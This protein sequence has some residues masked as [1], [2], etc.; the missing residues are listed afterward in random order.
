MKDVYYYVSTL[1]FYALI[2]VGSLF[3]PGV[4]EIFEIVGV[5]CVNA[6][7]FLF[8]ACFYLSASNQAAK[9]A[10]GKRTETLSNFDPSAVVSK[11]QVNQYLRV[12]AWLQ[13]FGGICAFCA[14]MYNQINSIFLMEHHDK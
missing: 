1:I 14:G 10:G 3:I 5:V 7:A 9:A 13:L 11:P 6:L 12:T 2:I 4:D 8:P